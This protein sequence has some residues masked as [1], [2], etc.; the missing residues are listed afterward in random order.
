M[1]IGWGSYLLSFFAWLEVREA[2]MIEAPA[3]AESLWIVCLGH[4]SGTM[5]C[6][7]GPALTGTPLSK[8]SE[9]MG[10]SRLFKKGAKER[11][12]RIPRAVSENVLVKC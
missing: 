6:F 4:N 3:E 10:V 2:M 7:L 5:I 12:R 11:E 8:K 9:E 1:I